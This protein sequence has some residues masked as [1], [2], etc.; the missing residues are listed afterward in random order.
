MKKF[1]G[2]Y[3]LCKIFMSFINFR[4]FKSSIVAG[5]LNSS[6]FNI[7]EMVALNIFQI[8]FWEDFLLRMHV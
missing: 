8:W 6:S 2:F 7:L 1:V 4:V 5:L 3:D